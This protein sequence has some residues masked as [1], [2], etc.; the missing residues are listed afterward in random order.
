M[1]QQESWSPPFC[2]DGDDARSLA[3][4]ATTPEARIIE[5]I[6]LARVGAE[7]TVCDLGCGDGAVLSLVWKH[8]RAKKCVGFEIND[9]LCEAA[10]QRLRTETCPD[11][12]LVVNEDVVSADLSS[13]DVIFIWLQPWAVDMLA[14]KLAE[15]ITRN[16]ARVASYQWPIEALGKV[17][18]V[19]VGVTQNLYLYESKD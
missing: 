9:D 14:E 5:M 1:D 15:C 18:K 4:F 12:Y 7:D 8:A 10:T 16:R 11:S 3:P 6:K 19:T 2:G 17:F 13:F